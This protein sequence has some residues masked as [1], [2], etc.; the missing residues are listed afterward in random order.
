MLTFLKVTGFAIIDEL[1]VEFENG[2]NV[3][4]GETGAGKSIIINALST[5]INAKTSSEMVRSSANHAEVTG[6]FFRGDGEYILKRVINPS[7]RS[8]ALLNENPVTSAR[9]EELGDMLINIYGQNEFQHLLDKAN[10]ISML[11]GI[12]LLEGERRALAEKVKEMKS[13]SGLLET[14]KREV[15][16][17]DKES[18]LLEFQVEEIEK[19]NLREGEEGEIKERLKMLKDTERIHAILSS[20]AEGMYEGDHAVH[21]MLQRFA[22]MLRPFGSIEAMENLRAKI[23]ST[24]F[25]VED[26]LSEVKGMEKTLDDDPDELDKA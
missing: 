15:E 24:C 1:Q 18:A 9:L 17:R 20:V 2:F 26:I 22:S 16:G 12:L 7:G 13:I 11:D 23:E 21:G 25:M 3:I 6:H 19:A 5:L 10:Y 8:R 4:T 14:K